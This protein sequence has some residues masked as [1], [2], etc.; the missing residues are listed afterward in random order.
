VSASL[1]TEKTVLI[2]LFFN[3]PHEKLQAECDKATNRQVLAFVDYINIIC[4]KENEI[5]K[6]YRLCKSINFTMMVLQMGGVLNL[7]CFK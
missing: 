2:S 4:R 5:C 6:K 7:P 1:V 3:F